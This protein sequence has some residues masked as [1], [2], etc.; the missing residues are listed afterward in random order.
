MRTKIIAVLGLTIAAGGM[1]LARAADEMDAE[2]KARV[3]RFEKGPATIN[4]S[5]YPEGI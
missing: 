4:V 5:K 1:L 3:E 2:T